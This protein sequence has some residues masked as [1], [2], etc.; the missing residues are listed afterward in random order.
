MNVIELFRHAAQI[1]DAIAVGVHKA[2]GINLINNRTF[3]P[4]T[5]R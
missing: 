5:H 4:I 2:L 3:E 1:A